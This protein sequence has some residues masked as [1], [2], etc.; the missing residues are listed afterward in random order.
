MIGFLREVGPSKKIGV[1]QKGSGRTS[2]K[3]I[4]D[5]AEMEKRVTMTLKRHNFQEPRT[6]ATG[7]DRRKTQTFPRS[8]RN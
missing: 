5:H 7:K 2:I 1:I 4:L 8:E 3:V 6:L